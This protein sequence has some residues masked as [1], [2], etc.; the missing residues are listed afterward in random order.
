MFSAPNPP[1][2][3]N[4]QT[5]RLNAGHLFKTQTFGLNLTYAS[6]LRNY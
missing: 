4:E 3:A 1:I 2:K 6:I 5:E